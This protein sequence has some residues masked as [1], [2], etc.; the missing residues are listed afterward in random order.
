MT[1]LTELN[2]DALGESINVG[3]VL[4][5]QGLSEMIGSTVEFSTP[6]VELVE[7][8][9]IN[10]SN[11]RLNAEKFGVVSQKATNGLNAEVMLLFAEEDV[12]HIVEKVMHIEGMDIEVIRELEGEAMCELGNIMVNACLSSIADTFHA[13]IESSIPQYVSRTREGL[14]AYIRHDKRQE[15]LLASHVDLTLGEHSV[16]GKLFFLMNA[17]SLKLN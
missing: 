6:N 1:T 5:A 7:L 17:A 3:T 14:V 16:A 12:L 2:F 10:A 13:P 15:F 8:D 4:A 9:R 11:L